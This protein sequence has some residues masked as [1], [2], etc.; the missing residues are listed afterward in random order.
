[1]CGIAG[2]LSPGGDPIRPSLQAM[3]DSMTHRGPDDAGLTLLAAPPAQAGFSFRRLAI[4]DLSPAANQPMVDP[5]TGNVLVFNG[6]VYNYRELRKELAALGCRFR[7][8]SDTEVVLK[9]YGAHGVDCLPMLRGMFG[10][11]IWDAKA[12]RLLL[13]RDR[14]GIKPLY[15]SRTSR[16]LAF[17]SEVRALLASG[18]VRKR[19][20]AAGLASYLGLGAVQDPLT[21]VE[22]VFALLPGHYA[23]CSEDGLSTHRYWSLADLEPREGPDIPRTRAV[24]EV[25]AQ[26]EESVA[27]HL[28]S[29]APLGVFLSGGID[30]SAMVSLAT[31]A[32]GRPPKTISVVFDEAGY[33]EERYIHTVASRYQTEHVEVRLPSGM[34]LDDLPATLRAMDQPTRDGVNTFVV[35]RRAREAGLT[36]LLSGLG[37]DELFGG[38]PSFRW[39]QQSQW[40]RRR[41]PQPVLGLAGLAG[42]L[43][44][45][46]TD[47]FRKLSHWA[48]CDGSVR[49]DY[50]LVRELFSPEDQRRLAPAL[51]GSVPCSAAA[52]KELPQLDVFGRVSAMEL[53]YYL[54]NILLRDTDCMGMAHSL[55]IRPPFLDHHLVT[56]ALTLPQRV[57]GGSGHLKPLLVDAVGDLPPE[58]A[59]RR[60]HGF[61]LPFD[62][63]MREPLKREIENVL[64]QAPEYSGGL[65]DPGATRAVWDRYISGKGNWGRPWALFALL[66]WLK[67]Y[68]A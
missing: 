7:S 1:L 45:G 61:V 3:A 37:G 62:I 4:I 32:A 6:E 25:R 36:V 58:I 15:Y 68:M 16:G 63:W 22:D 55:E 52:L 23:L 11:A 29:D 34:L 13:A 51:N 39:V 20:S 26:L 12:G 38:Y 18:L 35:S 41:L 31:R 47:R 19:V 8:E 28:V 44:M 30:S 53:N 54:A 67:T 65:L 2:V 5:E 49:E 14:L 59:S 48:G 9:A 57:K 66:Q 43:A 64:H 10:L 24:E 56:C 46:D 33:S 60:K 21:M 50:L 17:A 40:L 42:R 27:M